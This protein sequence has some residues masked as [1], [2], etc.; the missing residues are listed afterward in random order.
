M[1]E[2]S[3]KPPDD[4]GLIQE[5]DSGVPEKPDKYTRRSFFEGGAPGQ[6]FMLDWLGIKYGT[7]DK[8]HAAAVILSVLLLTLIGILFV[9]GTIVDRPWISTALQ[10]LGPAFTFVAGV[11][12][13]KS[14]EDK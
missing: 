6:V 8:G 4:W 14:I 12:V 3:N 9:L 13:G 1:K 10:I 11:A 7:D 2:E 5:D